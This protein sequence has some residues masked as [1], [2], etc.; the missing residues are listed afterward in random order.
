MK[1]IT[2]IYHTAEYQIGDIVMHVDQH[3]QRLAIISDSVTSRS[4]D[5]YYLIKFSNGCSSFVDPADIVPFENGDLQN[6]S[7]MLALKEITEC[8]TKPIRKNRPICE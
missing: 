8:G 1:C 7:A 6:L 5:Q 2:T 3:G 4:G